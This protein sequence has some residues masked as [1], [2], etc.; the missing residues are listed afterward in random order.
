[1]FISS[2]GEILLIT[3]KSL[4]WW[5][6]HFWKYTRCFWNIFW[7]FFGYRMDIYPWIFWQISTLHFGYI[8]DTNWIYIHGYSG[9]YPCSILDMFWIYIGYISMDI[10]VN[11]HAPFWI[12]NG[13]ISMDISENIHTYISDIYPNI[14]KISGY[15]SMDILDIRQNIHGYLDIFFGYLDIY[16][17]CIQK[18]SGYFLDINSGVLYPNI[19]KISGYRLD[20]YPFHIQISRYFLDIWIYIQISMDIISDISIRQRYS[21]HAQHSHFDFENSKKVDLVI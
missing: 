1:M 11:I 19:Q 15:I 12:Y 9:K 16:L 5:N 10:L 3:K 20:I 18:I 6:E 8:M 14:Q 4:H 7:T 13:Y 17:I 21:C 2:S